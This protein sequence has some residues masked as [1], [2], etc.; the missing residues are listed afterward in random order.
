M[1]GARASPPVRASLLRKAILNQLEE[2]E[3]RRS[4]GPAEDGK[5]AA[6]PD[7]PPF[8]G[9]RIL[10]VED[11]SINRAVAKSL[12][13][14]FGCNVSLACNGAEAITMAS[15][16]LFD[17]IYMDCQMPELDGYQAT[18][19]IRSPDSANARTPIVAL[20]A[21]VLQT[22]RDRCL[23]AGMNDHVSKPISPD[24]LFAS[25]EKWLAR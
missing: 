18:E 1:A 15:G 23:A 21:S 2:P 12:L 14:K 16:T 6:H 13:V 10:V 11:N 7:E 17:L 5:P 19:A 9:S 25:L 8:R 24:T 3:G 20:T 4:M 22:D